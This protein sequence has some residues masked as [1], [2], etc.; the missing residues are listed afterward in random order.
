MT[1][2][3]QQDTLKE[4][5]GLES[6]FESGSKTTK[7]KQRGTWGEFVFRKQC[8]PGVQTIK[9]KQRLNRNLVSA[10]PT[11]IQYKN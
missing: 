3:S 8:I 4:G 6:V 2:Y 9:S 5:R 7:N 11:L 10:F 1:V